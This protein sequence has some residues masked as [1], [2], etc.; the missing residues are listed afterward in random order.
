MVDYFPS[1]TAFLPPSPS[2]PRQYV[3][4]TQ[5]WLHPLPLNLNCLAPSL[6][7]LLTQPPPTFTISPALAF[8]PTNLLGTRVP[9]FG[10]PLG[11]VMVEGCWEPG[12]EEG[13]DCM[14]ALCWK[15]VP[16]S[17]ITTFPH[18][19]HSYFERNFKI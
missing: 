13:D 14:P 15:V 19:S 4:I 9:N 10:A 3:I 5:T 6:R 7:Y 11:M 1:P 8:L 18:T 12:L 17:L 2:P 16:T